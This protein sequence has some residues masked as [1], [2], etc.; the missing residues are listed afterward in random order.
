MTEQTITIY[1]FIDDFFHAVGRKDD[2]H[3]KI[4]DAELLTTALLAARY[5]HGNLCSA[6]SYMQAHHG[7]R[8]IDKSGFTR[9]LHS[10]QPSCW[11]C[12]LPWA[13]ASRSSTLPQLT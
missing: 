6:Y 11:L 10:L 8:L 3:C 2:A 5:F 13:R 7:V 4:N 9:R 12:L 1:C